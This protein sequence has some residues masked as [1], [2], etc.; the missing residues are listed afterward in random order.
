MK[1]TELPASGL[2]SFF[3]N[4]VERSYI[5]SEPT[6]PK[7]IV[8]VFHGNGGTA[9]GFQKKYV[10]EK[11]FTH[12]IVIY[13]QGIPGIGGG[14]DPKGL[15][16]G[17]QRKSGDGND[18]D[19]KAIDVLVPALVREYPELRNQVYAMGHSN[20]GRFVYLLWNQRPDLFKGFIINAHQG[21]DLLENSV[22][23]KSA[24]IC[25][26]IQD[27]VV[28]NA[29]QMKSVDL[30]K[31][32]LHFQDIE[33]KSDQLTVYTGIGKSIRLFHFIH[34]GGHDLPKTGLPWINEFLG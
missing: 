8:I 31:G 4:E 3:V 6:D 19:L 11:Y 1:K 23:A 26:G 21:V 10:L 9:D 22:P 5:K 15:K 27:K 34:A 12:S 29:N 18:R 30:I 14:F 25:T 28:N 32:A 16:N 7:N 24:F 33:K 20:G 2:H 13:L 17:W